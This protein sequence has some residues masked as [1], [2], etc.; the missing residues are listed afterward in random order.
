VSEISPKAGKRQEMASNQA[1]QNGG[2]KGQATQVR[3]MRYLEACR[4]G[5]VSVLAKKGKR[6]QR[7]KREKTKRYLEA[8][9]EGLVSVNVQGAARGARGHTARAGARHLLERRRL[10]AV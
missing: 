1:R 8:C 6:G 7:G 10:E 9:R 4:V 2:K 3:C 5:L